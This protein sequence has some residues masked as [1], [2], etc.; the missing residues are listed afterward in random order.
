MKR[1]FVCKTECYWLDR[2]WLPGKEY[3]L[4]DGGDVPPRH[5]EEVDDNG[6]PVPVVEDTHPLEQPMTL[7]Q[8]QEA[9]YGKTRLQKD[10]QQPRTLEEAEDFLA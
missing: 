4:L 2:R 6:K 3:V 9:I 7:G 8:G 10:G 5:F 1:T